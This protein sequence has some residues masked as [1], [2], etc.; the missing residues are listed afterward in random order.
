[1]DNYIII[2]L[3]GLALIIVGLFLYRLRKARQPQEAYVMPNP[4]DFKVAPQAMQD[5]ELIKA[6]NDRKH[7]QP[8]LKKMELILHQRKLICKLI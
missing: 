8:I 3:V 6:F 7:D 4:Y 2:Y 5:H 1:M